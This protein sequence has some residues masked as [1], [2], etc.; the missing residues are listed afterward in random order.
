MVIHE[1]NDPDLIKRVLCHPEIYSCIIDDACPGRDEFEPPIHPTIQYVAG[2][3]GGD[4]IGV[5]IYHDKGDMIKTHIQVL[6][7]YREQYA[8]EFARMA[9]N[10]GKAKNAM[11]Y[12]EIPECFP[13]VKRFAESFG[14]KETGKTPNG[15]KINGIIHDVA[16]MRL[17]NHGCCS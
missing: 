3:V 4:I 9:L 8:R 17:D 14:F 15:R 13:N 11:L 16:V 5:M 6:P 12:A 10:F 1:I 2:F 7:V